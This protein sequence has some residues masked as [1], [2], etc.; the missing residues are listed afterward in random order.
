MASHLKGVAFCFPDSRFVAI[1]Q[2]MPG[3]FP[4]YTT[5][6]SRN[7]QGLSFLTVPEG[8]KRYAGFQ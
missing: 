1:R 8:R 6:Y 7:R 4:P 5:H 2:H 3:M